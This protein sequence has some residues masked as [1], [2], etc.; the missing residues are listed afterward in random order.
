MP[1][2]RNGPANS[3]RIPVAASRLKNQPGPQAHHSDLGVLLL[4]RVEKAFDLCLV[5][6]VEAR[7]DPVTRPVLVDESVLRAGRVGADGRRVDE[8]AHARAL[9]RVEQTAAAVHVDPRQRRLVVRR[10]DE[11]CEVHDRIRAGQ[12]RIEVVGADVGS[13]PFRLRQRQIRAPAGHADDRLD[14]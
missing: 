3:L 9:H 5:A 7:R 8:C 1:P 11:P 10:L 13:R 14:A 4:V 12:H 6:R 2:G